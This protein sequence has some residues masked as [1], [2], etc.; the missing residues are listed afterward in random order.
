MGSVLSNS[1][2]YVHSDFN[3]TQES[4]TNVFIHEVAASLEAE[5]DTQDDSSSDWD[6]ESSEGFDNDIA[7]SGTDSDLEVWD[8]ALIDH[9]IDLVTVNDVVDNS[10]YDE[11]KYTRT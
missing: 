6:A 10:N 11:E 9:V 8:T 2:V 7:S 5:Q 4:K 1:A 3:E